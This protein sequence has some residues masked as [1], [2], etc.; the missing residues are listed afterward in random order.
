MNTAAYNVKVSEIMQRGD[1]YLNVK[2]HHALQDQTIRKI[3]KWDNHYTHKFKLWFAET[4]HKSKNLQKSCE[5][6]L[7]N[8]T[9]KTAQL[10]VCMAPR[11][12]TCSP[13]FSRNCL[14]FGIGAA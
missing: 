7:S 8:K 13:R 10:H 4:M 6:I 12:K 5:E 3:F 14:D 2:N 9:T 1:K 11:S